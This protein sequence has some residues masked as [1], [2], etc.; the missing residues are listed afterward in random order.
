MSSWGQLG[1]F[2]II[3]VTEIFSKLQ[4]ID[5]IVTENKE[6]THYNGDAS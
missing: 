3:C 1:I 5:K 4:T 2:K 6:P